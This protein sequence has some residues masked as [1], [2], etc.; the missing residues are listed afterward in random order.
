MG[1][2][3]S[4]SFPFIL[5]S[6]NVKS[7]ES[8]DPTDA[9]GQDTLVYI[10]KNQVVTIEP[11][12]SSQTLSSW[13]T[14]KG[15]L[16]FDSF[17]STKRHQNLSLQTTGSDITESWKMV[18]SSLNIIFYTFNVCNLKYA[19]KVF[20][21]IIFENVSIE[22]LNFLSLVSQLNSFI[23]IKRA[24][25][26]SF[27]SNLE[28]NFQINSATSN[29]KLSS[30]SLCV[31]V[32]INPRYEGSYLNLKLRQRYLKGNFRVL[33]LG[34]IL[35]LTFPIS[36]LGSNLN[37]FKS[38]LE[39]NHSLCKDIIS[40]ENPMFVTNTESLK[41]NSFQEVFNFFRVLKNLNVVSQIW[42]GLNVLSMSLYETGLHSFSRFSFLTNK[43][44]YLFC[45]F[46]SLNVNLNNVPNV[47][48]ITKSR[49][50]FY[51]N[52]KGFYKSPLF[53]DQNINVGSKFPMLKNHFYL[54]GSAF[55]EN[56][57]TYVNAEGFKKFESKLI[58][59]K[60]SKSDWQ[61]LRKFVQFML[62]NKHL[63]CLKDNKAL[64]YSSNSFFNFKNFISFHFQA[65]Q[66]L[67]NFN[68]YTSVNTQKFV[69]YQ[70]VPNFKYVTSKFFKTQKQKYWLV[71]FFTGGKD[72]FCQSSLTLHRCSANYKL[73]VTNF[74]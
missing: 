7:Y 31:L 42:S 48:T 57:G 19:N 12:F 29:A 38:I 49:I 53:I 44:L 23:K 52:L 40:A 69:L 27:N 6:W 36:F 35:N 66:N 50:L 64:F 46:Y 30:S 62:T 9:F 32:G 71:D 14:D 1:A 21:I 37:I 60:N 34:P 5:R 11:Q 41:L 15:R 24:E 18:F 67:V 45:A 2:L 68:E 28:S 33:A 8:F 74:F 55:F 4:K 20:F 47:S 51:K 13:L 70:K 63:G 56:S 43:D 54:P 26:C 10:N 25:A 73:Q 22:I 58:L 17:F 61:I 3:T 16:F 65:T 59:K 39:G 72:N